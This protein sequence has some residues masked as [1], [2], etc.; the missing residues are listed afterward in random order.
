MS[1]I[2]AA[3]ISV[4]AVL[5]LLAGFLFGGACGR[6]HQQYDLVLLLDA[7]FI[8]VL[9]FLLVAMAAAAIA[10]GLVAALVRP[11]WLCAVIF[12]LSS[13]SIR[14]KEPQRTWSAQRA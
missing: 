10:G 11:L 6:I 12:F 9:L 2:R 14:L 5:L 1:A 3:K 4:L 7:S 8:Q 13:C